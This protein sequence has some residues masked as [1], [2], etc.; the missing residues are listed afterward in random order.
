MLHSIHRLFNDPTARRVFLWLRYPIFIG[1]VAALAVYARAEW[2]WPAFAVS[3]AGEFI[4]LWSFA[5][6]VKNEQ[7]TARGPY[8][9]V[10]NPMYLGRFFLIFGLLM[11]LANPWVL[12]GYTVLYY[13]YM[14]NRVG[15]EEKRL[16]GLLGKPYARYCAAV[17][18]FLPDPRRL[19]DPGMRFFSLPVMLNNNGHWNLLSALI[20]WAAIY[21]WLNYWR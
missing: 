15:R 11:L 5:S 7:L 10:R 17:N 16:A 14:V 19:A 3:M 20:A 9:L 18:R 21:G 1:V 2:F 13:F 8:V 4:Q 12:L 6:L